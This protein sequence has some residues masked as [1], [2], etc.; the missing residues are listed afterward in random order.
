MRVFA[1]GAAL[2][3]LALAGPA[4]AQAPQPTPAGKAGMKDCAAQWQAM[5]KAGTAK[6]SYHDF[7]KT[8]LAGGKPAAA[9]AA[10][11]TRTQPQSRMQQVGPEPAAKASKS[12]PKG[13]NADAAGA[14]AKCKDGAFSH[15]KGHTGACS[16]HG[17]VAQWLK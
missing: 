12:A 16:H 11:E 1:V 8:C 15:S 14:T 6:G 2:A 4:F 9:G 3:S 10:A 5:K 7:S 17:G 13:S